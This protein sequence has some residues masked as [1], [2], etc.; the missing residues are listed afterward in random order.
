MADSDQ[1]LELSPELQAV[2]DALLPAERRIMQDGSRA[3]LIKRLERYRGGLIAQD[4]KATATEITAEVAPDGQLPPLQ[5]FLPYF[6][7]VPV[8]FAACLLFSPLR[9]SN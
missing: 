1:N 5:D 7:A 4:A 8:I 9:V 2:Y 6:S 3:D